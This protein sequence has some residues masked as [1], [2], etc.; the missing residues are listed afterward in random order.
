M[1]LFFNPAADLLLFPAGAACVLFLIGNARWGAWGNVAASALTLAAAIALL[2][3]HELPAGRAIAVD[4]LNVAFVFLNALVGFTAS[5]FGKGYLAHDIETKRIDAGQMRIYHALYQV[6]MFVMN[7]ALLTRIAGLMWVAIEF[8]TLITVWMVGLYRTHEAL[9]AAWK[10]FLLASIG[11]ALALFGTI[12]VYLAAQGHIGTGLSAMRWDNLA[13]HAAQF[14]PM[15]L[16]IGF[17]F[18][19]IGYGTKAGLVPLHAWLPDAHAEGPTPVSAILSGL[20][21]NLS[22]YAILR[23]K[24]ILVA[25]TGALPP[26]PLL[27]AFGVVSL[28]VAALMLY[29]RRD[30]KRFFAYSSVEHVGIITLAFGI[31]GPLANFAGLLHMIL[32]SLAKSGIFFAVGHIIRIKG[33]QKFAEI[34]GLAISHPALGWT[35]I[36]GVAALGAMPPFG[37]FASE[38]LVITAAF[39]F[40]PALAGI[41]ILGLL[42]ALGG[43]FLRLNAIAFGPPAGS[44]LPDRV[45]LWPVWLH[46]TLVLVGGLYLPTILTAWLQNAAKLLG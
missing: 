36:A 18:V 22:L 29:R 24:T 43:L 17:V 21:L 30:I 44:C 16:S 20:L 15:L 5:W 34:S 19:L 31:G 8:S 7:L 3:R 4:D 26:G 9:E 39:H 42:L 6:L 33:T 45:S 12:V 28:F 11:I 1:T 35:L 23:F 37:T 32:H 27:I 14:D 2:L 46:L 38:F 41:A 13:A 40:H 25:N 10:Y